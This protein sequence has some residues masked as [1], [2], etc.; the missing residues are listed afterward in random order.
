MQVYYRDKIENA[1]NLGVDFEEVERVVL[2]KVVDAKWMDHIDAMDSLRR[3]I[4]LKAYGQQ[5]PVVAYK[6]EGFAMFDEMIGKIQEETVALLM[7]VNVEQAP[8]REGVNLELVVSSNGDAA[9]KNAKKPIVKSNK[10]LGRN[11]A[12]PCG[13][14]KKYKNCCWDKDH[15]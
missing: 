13:S 10:N 4:G 12:C 6:R 14:G 1:K 2:L 5:D 8:K 11:D 9:K 15:N 3:G 7:R